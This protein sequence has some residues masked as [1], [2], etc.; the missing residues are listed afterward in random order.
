[1]IKRRAVFLGLVLLPIATRTA[2]AKPA[3]IVFK[4]PNCGCCGAWV[5]H[6]RAAGFAAEV[7][8]EPQMHQTKTRLGVPMELASCHTAIVD[9]FLIEGHVPAEAIH[10]VLRE[11]PAIAGIAVP[12]MPIG[13]PGMEVPGQRPDPFD[14]IG[15]TRSGGRMVFSSYAQG[16]IPR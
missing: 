10:N 5:D 13:S 11:R 8:I 3:M 15:F 12:G 16:Y 7:R 9:G 6:V 1:M 14:V 2:S 4:D